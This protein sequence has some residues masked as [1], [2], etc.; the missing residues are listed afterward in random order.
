MT[1]QKPRRPTPAN[2]RIRRDLVPPE[3]AEAY[4][5]ELYDRLVCHHRIRARK[6]RDEGWISQPDGSWF[7]P[8]D[9]PNGVP[10]P[11]IH[12]LPLDP[13]NPL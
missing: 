13:P 2:V 3:I 11:D 8:I 12:V 10:P 5:A 6:A 1:R 4:R 7:H 9:T